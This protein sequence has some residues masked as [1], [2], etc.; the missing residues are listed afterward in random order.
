MELA[1]KLINLLGKDASLIEYAEDR[2]GHDF[3][4]AID[5]SKLRNELGWQPQVNF[6]EGLNKTI[7]WHKI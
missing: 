1:K 6:A 5:D 3:R 2:K 4:Y 7:E